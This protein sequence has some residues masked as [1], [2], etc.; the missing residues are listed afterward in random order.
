[1]AAVPIKIGITGGASAGHVVPALAVA[2][3]LRREGHD[4]LV[5]VGRPG[6]IEEELATRAGL[7]FAPVASAG[8]RRYRSAKNLLMPF[9]VVRGLGQAYRT[10]RRERP[11]LVF[12]KGSYVAVPVGVAA[13]LT[14]VPLVIHESDYSLGLANRIL[15]PFATRVLLSSPDAVV[16]GRVARKAVRTGLP[17]RDDLAA[18]DPERLRRELGFRPDSRVLL[19]FCGSLGSVRVNEAVRGA[20]DE[21]LGRFEVLHVTGKGNL[22]EALQDRPGYH[23]V[24]Y[25]HEDMVDALWL[26][27]VVV[28]RAG[29]STLSELGAL[30]KSAVLVPLPATASR[31][32]QI[33]NA[34][35]YAKQ[36]AASVVPDDE[37]LQSALP[38]AC[39]DAAAALAD[40]PPPPPAPEAVHEAAARVAAIV[41]DLAQ[42]R[43]NRD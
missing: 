2:Q 32:D 20:L 30:S 35:L 37:A 8:L 10:M 43:R 24:E 9:A 1:V 17:V 28:A 15:A 19:V 29:A 34:R 13:R 11:D 41:A 26:A 4:D 21:L 36:H 40:D 27:D 6:S 3:Q 42:A 5:Y 16:S 23:Q 39:I 7:R 22:A 25:L 14:G 12:A 18:G 38:K 31:G 33:V